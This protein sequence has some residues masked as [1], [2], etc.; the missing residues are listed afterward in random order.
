M[1]NDNPLQ[2]VLVAKDEI[3]ADLRIELARK[4]DVINKAEEKNNELEAKMLEA[5][6]KQVSCAQRHK[7]SA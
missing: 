5:N 2:P 7:I 3:I 6:K 4:N 1:A